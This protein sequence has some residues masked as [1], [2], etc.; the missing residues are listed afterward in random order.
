MN[1]RRPPPSAG[2]DRGP[3][4]RDRLLLAVVALAI[5]AVTAIPFLSGLH[6]GFVFDDEPNLVENAAYRGLGPSHLRWMFTTLYMGHYQ[7]LT[8]LTLALD[9]RIWG[10]ETPFGFLLTNLLLHCASAAAVFF[11]A[12]RLIG[13]AKGASHEA[14]TRALLAAAAGAALLFSLHPLRVESVSWATERRDVLSGLLLLLSLLAWLRAVERSEATGAPPRRLASVVLFALALLSK[15]IGVTLPVV[16]LL[17][18]VHPLRRRAAGVR[19]RTLVV[20][21]WPWLALSVVDGCAALL[22]QVHVASFDSLADLGPLGRLATSAYGLGFYVAKLAWPVH[23]SA[24]YELAL[25]VDV[26]R[27]RYVATTAGVLAAGGLLVWRARRDAA[28][29]VAAAAYA[30]LLAPLLGLIQCGPHEAADR[31]SYLP[32]IPL[33]LLAGG[34]LHRV[35]AT[36]SLRVRA[37]AATAGVGVLTLL[38]VAT[39]RQTRVWRSSLTLW[40]N[41]AANEPASSFA[42]YNF[43]CALAKAGRRVAAVE[44]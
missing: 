40:G 15:E 37:A 30:V 32:S 26:T 20:E 36:P 10:T 41:A 7:P 5:A 18:D 8:W 44:E 12:L 6:G 22:A 16:L 1:A 35:L 43:G 23:L 27:L 38:A 31:Y 21:K 39:A 13:R 14:P 25:P 9:A 29:L 17:L 2:A 3:L 34:A 28:P 33:V 24:I 11:V 19:W 4:R 42:H